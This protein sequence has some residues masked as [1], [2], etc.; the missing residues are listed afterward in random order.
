MV[1]VWVMFI[2]LTGLYCKINAA[3][4]DSHDIVRAFVFVTN[5]CAKLFS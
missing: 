4:S 3:F 5:D 1:V 2:P